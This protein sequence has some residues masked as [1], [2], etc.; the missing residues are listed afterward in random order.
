VG[1]KEWPR[2]IAIT[3]GCGKDSEPLACEHGAWTFA[4]ADFKRGASKWRCPTGECQPKSKW[5][6]ADRRNPLIPRGTKRWSSLYR[7]ALP[8]SASS[9]A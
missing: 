9:G 8:S 6:N 2:S 7:A 3:N 5:I 1:D 4:G